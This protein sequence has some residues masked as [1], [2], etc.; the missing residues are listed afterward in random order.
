MNLSF[1]IVKNA[2]KLSLVLLVV[3]G[4][5]YPLLMTGISQII[6]PHEA[7]GSVVYVGDTAVGSEIVGQDFTDPRFM[8]CRPSAVNYNTYTKESK[9]NGEYSGVASG[10]NNYAPS[11]PDLAARVSADIEKFLKVNPH[12]EIEDIP[13]DLVTASGSGLDPHI[14]PKSAEVQIPAISKATGISEKTLRTFVSNN[15]TK[16]FLGVFGEE[17]VNVLKVNLKIAK[18]LNLL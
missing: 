4:I 17:T 6:F 14:S 2:L 1:R 18:E 3:C 16:K 5:G 13:T 7:N 15:T 10:S 9:E 12:I 8:K 11:N